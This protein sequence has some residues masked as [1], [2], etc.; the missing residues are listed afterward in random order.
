VSS[1]GGLDLGL[2]GLDRD[3][4]GVDVALLDLLEVLQRLG[5]VLTHFEQVFSGHQFALLVDGR[6]GRTHFLLDLEGLQFEFVETLVEDLF[7]E[8][9]Q[10][11]PLL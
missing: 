8:A 6:H 7:G 10:L 9:S 11:A 2:P 1:D 3:H 5:L 4:R